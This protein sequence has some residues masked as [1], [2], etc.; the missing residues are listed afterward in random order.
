MSALA[1]LPAALRERVDALVARE[2]NRLAQPKKGFLRY[3]RPLESLQHLKARQL[4]L[5]QDVVQIGSDTEVSAE[6]RLR[7]EAALRA[8][9]PWRK[10][11]FSVFG[12][13]VDAEWRSFRKWNRLAP[14]LPDL[15]GKIVADIGS[16]NGYYLFRMAAHAPALALGFEP[17]PQHLFC[18]RMLNG[19]AGLDNLHTLPLGVEHLP[20]FASAFDVVFLM[21]IL[22]HRISPVEAL[23]DVRTA[24]RPGGTLIV[25]SQAI[26]GDGPVALFPRATYAKV[27]GTWF[28]PTGTCLAHW[29]ERAGFNEVELFCSH[30]MSGEEQRR[31]DWMTFESYTDFLDPADPG[32]T[33][34]GYPAPYRVYL[35]GIAP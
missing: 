10:G 12:V 32:R 34:E 28:V 16:N 25:E 21:G 20:L 23:K 8:F 5:D 19:I 31:T 30:P 7:V 24:M 29:M 6:E 35:K 13:E 15:E 22:Y 18:F 27:P 17:Y 33:V 14:H 11:P 9:M 3:R 4:V 26:P 2:E 1:Q